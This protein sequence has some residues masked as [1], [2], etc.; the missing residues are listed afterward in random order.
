MD[1]IF[2][3]VPFANKKFD[4][5]DLDIDISDGFNAWLLCFA[6]SQYLSNM[7]GCS[8]WSPRAI[9]VWGING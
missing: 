1:T 6:A 2:S 8:K 3:S 9:Q 5:Y 7:D 4:D